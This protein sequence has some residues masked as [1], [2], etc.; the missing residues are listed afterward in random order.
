MKGINQ[1]TKAIALCVFFLVF[2]LFWTPS[3]QAQLIGGEAFMQGDHLEVG[4]AACGNFG[5]LGLPP[6]GYHNNVGTA[7]LGF[8][9]DVDRD[10]WGTAPPGGLNYCGDYFVP[11]SPEEGFGIEIAG[12][13]YG[14]FTRCGTNTIPGTIGSYFYDGATGDHSTSW[15]GAVSGLTVNALTF[16][17]DTSLYFVTRVILINT[18][19]TTLN[20]I[21][22]YRNVDPDNEQPW[23]GS[24]MTTNTIVSNNGPGGEALVSAV[25]Q[26]HGC[27]LGLGTL[28]SRARVSWGG[29]FVRDGSDVWDGTGVGGITGSGTTSCDCA[30]SISFNVG[31]L[32]P[33]ESTCLAFAYI[34]NEADLADALAA[35]AEPEYLADGVVIS[36]TCC[37]STCLG[38]PVTLE[39]ANGLGYFWDWSPAIGLSSTTGSSITAAPPVTT[40]YTVTG[41]SGCG[42]FTKDITVIVE[43]DIE[44]PLLICPP[45]PAVSS[46]SPI[47]PDIMGTSTATDN[48][49][50]DPDIIFVQTPPAGDGLPSGTTNIVVTAT[51]LAGNTSTCVNAVTVSPSVIATITASTDVTCGGAANGTA[52]AT[53]TGGSP[54]YT[55]LWSNGATT[56]TVSGLPGGTHFVTVTDLT[57]CLNADAVVIDEPPAITLAPTPTNPSCGLNNG[58]IDIVASGGAPGYTYVWSNGATTPNVS[59]LAVGSYTVVVVD[60]I[61]CTSSETYVLTDPGPPG[62]S[63]SAI[64]DVTCFGSGNGTATASPVGGLAGYTYLW[65]DGQTGATAVGLSAGPYLVT[66]TDAAGCTATSLATISEPAPMVS[67][68]SSSSSTCGLP[69]GSATVSIAGGT[70]GYSYFWS[71]GHATASA[72]GLVGG[73]YTVTVTDANG[74]L[75]I[76]SI[77]VPDMAGPSLSIAGFNNVSC[78]G[79][80]DGTAIGA[81][82]GGTGS[83]TY[84][85]SDGQSTPTATG[86]SGGSYTLSVTDANGCLVTETV[87]IIEPT[88]V[89]ASISSNVD[90]T[91]FGADDGI[92]NVAGASSVPP[93]SYNWS[94]GHTVSSA[95]GLSPGTYV[96]T[97][98]D[99]DGCEA[100]T[101]VSITE[102]SPLLVSSIP[103]DATCPGGTDGSAVSSVG[104]G[105]PGYSYSW[106]TLPPQTTPTPKVSVANLFLFF[107]ET[108]I[109]S[110]KVSL[111]IRSVYKTVLVCPLLCALSSDCLLTS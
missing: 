9:A 68:M 82:S 102:P 94:S 8:V 37:V 81:G 11:G 89:T 64:S 35:T 62:V 3:I 66:V 104:G 79:F 45:A 46:C 67:T 4:V 78:A 10:G 74:C 105:T 5:T 54:G 85:W 80:A 22:Y 2:S 19:A 38:E 76:Q 99:L 12:V 60:A 77:L 69:N 1:L 39:I 97:V 25:G 109:L 55:Y 95:T 92:A 26:A 34:L 57:G 70:P 15:T 93:L 88:P 87:S 47:V 49:T 18:S 100:V 40:T 17:N 103:T 41:S 28:D 51:D 24:F 23:T 6:L 53:A 65:S 83:L 36:D 44:P 42:T 50:P 56:P 101:S 20:N 108:K 7:G 58:T 29:F 52:A 27:Y 16:F 110:S 71:S 90:V 30:I 14:N 86:L 13:N 59:G 48:C 31:S 106:N 33:G 107:N 32:A 98:T 111:Q 73:T 72:F 43:P 75:E 96:V 91:C 21:Y 61:G 63:I 84:A